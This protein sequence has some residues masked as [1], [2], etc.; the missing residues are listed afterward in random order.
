MDWRV[1]A[2]RSRFAE[3]PSGRLF[4]LQGTIRRRDGKVWGED[5][6]VFLE[7]AGF[8]TAWASMPR[9][10]I[11]VTEREISEDPV[12]KP[13]FEEWPS[14]DDS[15]FRHFRDP[16]LEWTEDVAEPN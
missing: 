1:Y 3:V 2:D 12:L 7:T 14:G 8:D 6:H 11:V 15:A 16:V 13:L 9:P 4:V 5:W 10:G